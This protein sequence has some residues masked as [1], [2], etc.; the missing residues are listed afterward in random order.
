MDDW[1]PTKSMTQV[2]Y[3]IIPNWP[4]YQVGSDG[5]VW[6]RWVRG[7]CTATF[8]NW[9]PLSLRTNKKGYCSVTLFAGGPEGGVH[10]ELA[11]HR[12]VCEAFNGPCPD[13]QQC[14]HL[15]GNPSNNVST[16]LA[17]GTAADNHADQIRHGTVP[18]NFGFS[19]GN[20]KFSDEIIREI[21][22]LKGIMPRRQIA[23]R[24]RVSPSYVSELWSGKWRKALTSITQ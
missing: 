24:F 15:D 13:G 7:Q 17:W 12:I 14:R 16:N 8:G 3:K 22:A 4:A 1:C 18:H 19:N 20:C 23:D 9:K 2:E 10:K 11:V 5:T 6:T 21:K